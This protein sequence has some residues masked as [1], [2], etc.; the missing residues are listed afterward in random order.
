MATAKKLPSGSWR[1]RAYVGKGPDGKDKYKSFTA[2]TKKEAEY[3]AA[4][5]VRFD[6]EIAKADSDTFGA[7]ADRYIGS[8]SNILSPTT[9]SGYKKIKKNHLDEWEK[10]KVSDLTNSKI[11]IKIN[12]ISEIKSP[13]TV[14]NVYG[15]ITAVLY[16]ANPERR[17]SVSLPKKKKN[18]KVLPATE[19]VINAV[20]GT[21]VE[22]AAMLAMWMSLR[23]S[24]IRGLMKS[25]IID[26][27]MI[28]RHVKVKTE[29]GEE[30]REATKTYDSTRM[31]KLPQYILDLIE[32][33][34]TE[35]IV[36]ET[37]GRIYKRFQAA[38]KTAGI[39]RHM[40]FHDLR[41]LNASVMISLGVPDPYAMERGGWSSTNVLKSVYQHTFSKERLGADAKIDNYF[42][43][44]INKTTKNQGDMTQKHDTN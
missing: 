11:Q 19:D 15:F 8:K 44:I 14:R 1:V 38:L 29:N 6:R 32:K 27:Y 24:E 13:K 42:E 43:K 7:V 5:Y 17:I 16:Y 33:T 23:L 20:R 25:D 28:V 30:L 26:G 36:P 34:D 3:M 9:I 22:L 39:D 31:L 18:I 41:H 21:N 2:S 10:T 37:P 40:S 12:E 4:Q 35:F